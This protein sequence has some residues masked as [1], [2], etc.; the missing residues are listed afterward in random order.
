LLGKIGFVNP[1]PRFGECVP[2]RPLLVAQFVLVPV[3]SLIIITFY[4]RVEFSFSLSF[5]ATHTGPPLVFNAGVFSFLSHFCPNHYFLQLFSYGFLSAGPPVSPDLLT[6]YFPPVPARVMVRFQPRGVVCFLDPF[7][8]ALEF[9]PPAT[10]FLAV[11]S[12]TLVFWIILGRVFHF[13][14]Q[15]VHPPVTLAHLV[16]VPFF[17]FCFSLSDP[18]L[19]FLYYFIAGCCILCCTCFV[20]R[21]FKS[22]RVGEFV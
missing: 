17:F 16:F 21:Q 8:I 10:V 5:I 22:F 9:V 20:C 15:H 3:V 13:D 11:S 6:G 1:F 14:A 18:A 2:T 19:L 4:G 12:R 7:P